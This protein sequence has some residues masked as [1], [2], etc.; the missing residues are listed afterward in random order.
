MISDEQIAE[1]E[2]YCNKQ[3]DRTVAGASGVFS[4][5]LILELIQALRSERAALENLQVILGPLAHGLA[6]LR[7]DKADCGRPGQQEAGHD[8]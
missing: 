7:G 3:L 4:C 2:A 6:K 1:I 5:N 8:R